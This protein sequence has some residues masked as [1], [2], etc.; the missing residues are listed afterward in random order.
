MTQSANV[1]FTKPRIAREKQQIRDYNFECVTADDGTLDWDTPLIYGT[2]NQVAVKP[3][4]GLTQ[5]TDEFDVVINDIDGN[6]VLQG[7]GAN[8]SNSANTVILP[9]IPVNGQL[10]ILVTGGGTAKG[11]NIRIYWT[12]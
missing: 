9:N 6:D 5:P 1:T 4:S 11:L 2:V 10:N 8:C 12:W 7:S 3:D